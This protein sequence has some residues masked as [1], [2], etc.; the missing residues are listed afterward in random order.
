[1]VR[2][3]NS[4]SHAHQKTA[5]RALTIGGR[6]NWFATNEKLP[7]FED[8]ALVLSGS[9]IDC[10]DSL[11]IP[12]YEPNAHT[13]SGEQRRGIAQQLTLPPHMTNTSGLPNGCNPRC[14]SIP[15]FPLT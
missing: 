11:F 10:N 13:F 1:M 9:E 15:L 3:N 4:E 2:D 12:H 5:I 6:F 14:P 8:L 7:L